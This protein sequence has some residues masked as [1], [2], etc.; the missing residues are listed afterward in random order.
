[1]PRTFSA[2]QIAGAVAVAAIVGFGIGF[3]VGTTNAIPLPKSVDLVLKDDNST[4]PKCVPDNP[5][6]LHG[7]HRETIT[8]K[9]KNKCSA[10][11]YVKIDSFKPVNPNDT[12]GSA[13]AVLNPAAPETSAPVP[14][15]GSLDLS[16]DVREDTEYRHYKYQIL[17][18]GTAPD[19]QYV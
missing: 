10:D 17:L 13:V 7:H 8:W 4:P 14:S 18:K 15:R 3:K 19:A 6:G 9:I 11:Y 2:A 1:M 5:D 16:A 12:F